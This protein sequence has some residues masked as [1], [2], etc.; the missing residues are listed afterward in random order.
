[1]HKEVLDLLK[2]RVATDS[3]Q[4]YKHLRDISDLI[5]AAAKN[6]VQRLS[7]LHKD[8]TFVFCSAMGTYD[9]A[10]RKDIEG[11]YTPRPI[12]Y[13]NHPIGRLMDKMVKEHGWS[14]IPAPVMIT[15]KNG[16]DVTL[17]D[18]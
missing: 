4:V 2:R 15:A 8:K 5:Q 13:E 18:W 1:M 7:L 9:I 17:Y 6:E 10:W 14:S 16:K 3:D 11:D 12:R